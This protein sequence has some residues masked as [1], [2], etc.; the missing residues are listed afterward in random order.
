[1]ANPELPDD[2]P[3]GVEGWPNAG[4]AACAVDDAPQ[5]EDLVPIPLAAP[6]AVLPEGAPIGVLD[7]K[8]GLPNALGVCADEP[9]GEDFCPK[10]DEPPNPGVLGAP[11]AGR[12]G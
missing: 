6:N 10:A 9:Q 5:G 1:M 3:K 11:K 4:V 8:D 2:P 7:P 12:D